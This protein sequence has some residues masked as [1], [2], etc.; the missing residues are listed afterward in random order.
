MLA[1]V[2]PESKGHMMQ[3]DNGNRADGVRRKEERRKNADPDYRGPERRSGE[4]RRSGD[5]RRDK[6]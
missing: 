5:D 3:K 1:R 4:D 6:S 2:A